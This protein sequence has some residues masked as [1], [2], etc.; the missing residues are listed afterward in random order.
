MSRPKEA[1]GAP[2]GYLPIQQLCCSPKERWKI[3]RHRALW[4]LAGCRFV[5]KGSRCSPTGPA[6]L[7]GLAGS[8]SFSPDLTFIP[9]SQVLGRQPGHRNH[10][11][12]PS[13]RSQAEG[14]TSL[15]RAHRH[16]PLLKTS[17]Q[18]RLCSTVTSHIQ[19]YS[20]RLFLFA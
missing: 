20:L 1:G 15:Y 13:C 9:G 2:H 16:H 12:N 10:S 17:S 7:S 18:A 4:A 3:T 14:H 11:T 19:R 5:T 8:R 6:G